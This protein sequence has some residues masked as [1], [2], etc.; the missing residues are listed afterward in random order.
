MDKSQL[1]NTKSQNQTEIAKLAS[2]KHKLCQRMSARKET[3]L[4]KEAKLE[5]ISHHFLW[6][7]V[8]R[9]NM[10]VKEQ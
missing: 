5:M 10:I 1:Q 9:E 6:L 8:K 4:V 7:T 3:V 2:I